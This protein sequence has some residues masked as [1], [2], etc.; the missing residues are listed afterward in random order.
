MT[1]KSFR[2]ETKKLFVQYVFL[3]EKV[4]FFQMKLRAK[5]FSKTPKFLEKSLFL[6]NDA[7]KQGDTDDEES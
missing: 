1:K 3:E 2:D 4:F 6:S 5:K 7:S